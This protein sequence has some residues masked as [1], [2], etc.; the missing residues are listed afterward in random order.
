MSMREIDV[1]ETL[2]GHTS[3][4]LNA[5]SVNMFSLRYKYYFITYPILF[6]PIAFTLS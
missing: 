5:G 3:R 4:P 6:R 2:D 1:G